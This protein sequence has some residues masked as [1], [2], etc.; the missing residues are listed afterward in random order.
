MEV[1]RAVLDIPAN[2]VA[3]KLEATI[4]E[5]GDL[6]SV[7]ADLTLEDIRKAIKD[8]EEVILEDD[9]F[10]LTEEALAYLRGCN[11]ENRIH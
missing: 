8:G 11:D 9:E 6:R 5:D 1:V 10:C 3:I 4:Y 2:A 7:V